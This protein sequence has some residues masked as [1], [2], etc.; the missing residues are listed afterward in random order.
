MHTSIRHR[1]ESSTEA[2][3]QAD[4]KTRRAEELKYGGYDGEMGGRGDF[5]ES[6]EWDAAEES[7][8]ETEVGA[9]EG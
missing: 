9:V 6:C 7:I 4:D 2:L 8:E 3:L 5:E 1:Q